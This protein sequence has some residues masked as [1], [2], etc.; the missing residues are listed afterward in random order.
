MTQLDTLKQKTHAINTEIYALYLSY[1]DSRVKWYVRMLLALAI[2]YALSP[3][4]LVPDLTP[5]FGYLDDVVIVAAGFRISYQ[6][7]TK[8]VRQE[9]QLQAFEDMSSNTPTSAFALKI[10]SYAWLLL[11]S[12]LLVFCYKLLHMHTL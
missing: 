8:Q 12:L 1:R 2:G 3:V 10:V 5:V 4:D 11:F 6:L 9:A 7:L